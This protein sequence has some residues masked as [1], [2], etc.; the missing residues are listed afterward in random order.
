M[1]LK[2][3]RNKIQD[4]SARIAVIGLG[5]VGLP[6]ACEF[7]RA[8]YSVL[9]VDIIADRKSCRFGQTAGELTQN[10]QQIHGKIQRY[11]EVSH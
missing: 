1:S 8:G 9:G 4:K 3:L 10:A 2:E 7:A 11:G 6:V 5:Y